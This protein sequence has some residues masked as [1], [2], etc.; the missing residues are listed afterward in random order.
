MITI[1]YKNIYEQFI[2]NYKTIHINPWHEINEKQ[3]N[4]IYNELINSMNIDNEYNFTYFMNFIIK[5]LNGKSDAHTK[6]N[7][8]SALPINFRIFNNEVLINY[9]EE[10]KGSTLLSI[11]NI[12]ITT[13]V[14]EIDDIISY[15]TEGKRKYEIE[16]ALFNKY[17]LY[18]LPSLRNFKE[19]TYE[20]KNKNG[21]IIRKTFT[22]E[23]K[24]KPF[25]YDKFRYGNISE[26]NIIDN[27][28]IYKLN[29]LQNQFKSKI[30]KNIEELNKTDLSM[31]DTIII[32]LRGNTGGNSGLNQILINFLKQNLD[33]NLLCLTDYRI[34]SSASFTLEELRKL[35][36]TFI[37]EEISTPMNSYGNNKNIDIDGFNFAI[38]SCYFHKTM[39]LGFFNKEDFNERITPEILKPTIFTP[40]IL[41]EETKN[42][43]INNIDTILDYAISYSITKTKKAV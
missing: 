31:I 10:L 16:K 5:R 30:E 40:D 7:I 23:S 19:L 26:Y 13:I 20:I 39:N 3:L 2:E 9:P 43:Y 17:I 15:G 21:E 38:S 25:D 4:S 18:G 42:D 8:M 34:Y 36:A 11:N 41:V 1:K 24:N 14:K 28:L 22:D 29:S 37:G 12:S 6:L 32:D 27:C 35:N 33:K